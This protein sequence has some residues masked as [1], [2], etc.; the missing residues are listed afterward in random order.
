MEEMVNFIAGIPYWK[1][2]GSSDS[3]QVNE[4]WLKHKTQQEQ[5]NF[6]YGYLAHDLTNYRGFPKDQVYD[7]DYKAKP[8][9]QG[10]WNA[11]LQ[12]ERA[13]PIPIPLFRIE[14]VVNDLHNFRHVQ[15]PDK[16]KGLGDK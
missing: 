3:Q 4:D 14:N 10:D 5:I 15:C 12:S 2:K 16:T 13:F 6:P 7:T 8:Q 9:L 11:Y 1:Y